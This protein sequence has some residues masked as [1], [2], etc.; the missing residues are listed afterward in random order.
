MDVEA[1]RA[2]KLRF[3]ETRVPMH[4]LFFEINANLVTKEKE[5]K[6]EKRRE[7]GKREGRR[8]K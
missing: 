6:K 2:I 3:K 7:K 4:L 5:K 1:R 8:E